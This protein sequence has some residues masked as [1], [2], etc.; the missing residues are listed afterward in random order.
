MTRVPAP[1]LADRQALHD[2]LAEVERLA[3][4]SRLGRLAA[5]PAPYL[6]ALGHRVVAYRLGRRPLRAR[7]RTFYGAD[8]A[9]DLPAGTDIYLTGG[10][11]HDS[12]IRL[13]RY[14]LRAVPAGGTVLDVGA[15]YG[16]FA[17][18]AAE[19]VGPEGRV[20]ALEAAPGTFAILRDNASA[21]PQLTVHALA[22]AAEPGQLT[23][24]E[25][26][27]LHS[28]Y[29]ALAI[30]HAAAAGWA[31]GTPPTAVTVAATSLDD[32]A[33]ERGLRPD[34]VKVDVEGAE[35]AVLA[36]AGE[37][38]R[39]VRPTVV[40]ELL[41]ATGADGPHARAARLLAAAGYRPR[42]I[43][44]S[45]HLEAIED[46]VAYVAAVGESDNVVFEAG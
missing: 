25:F 2:G 33:R 4:A 15:H 28:E 26:D 8:L 3:R 9:V 11:S 39:R 19:L 29:N 6:L 46:A 32:L 41:P 30:A 45:G 5:R 18:L 38:L 7:A 13:A 14:L 10:K 37:L 17:L 36:G 43:A 27:A 20:E 42:R 12:E 44:A 16:Y 31:A 40:L 34:L 1:G 22:A 24:S 23:F 35:D 21:K